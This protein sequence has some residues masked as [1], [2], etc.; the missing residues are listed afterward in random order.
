MHSKHT[1]RSETA[2][3]TRKSWTDVLWPR[4]RKFEITA[5]TIPLPRS[6]MIRINPVE[7]M[8]LWLYFF[9]LPAASAFRERARW[10]EFLVLISYPSSQDGP[11]LPARISRVGPARNSVLFGQIIDSLFG[12]SL[13]RQM[14]EYWHDS[15]L[16]FMGLDFVSVCKNAKR[17][18]PIS[19]HLDLT[20]RH[21]Y[22]ATQQEATLSRWKKLVPRESGG[23]GPRST[24]KRRFA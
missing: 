3:L 17:T 1:I 20:L 23:N 22:F 12:P 16:L 2:K 7:T 18:R 4:R 9:F 10:N 11:S 19:S 6:P 14:A 13:F 21:C 24:P 5:T 8:V 15:F